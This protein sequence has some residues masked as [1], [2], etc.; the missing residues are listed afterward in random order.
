M[1]SIATWVG[2][3]TGL[4]TAW[5]EGSEV[6]GTRCRTAGPLTTTSVATFL[7]SKTVRAGMRPAGSLTVAWVGTSIDGRTSREAHSLPREGPGRRSPER[8]ELAAEQR[9]GSQPPELTPP[10]SGC[11]RCALLGLVTPGLVYG[12]IGQAGLELTHPE[13]ATENRPCGPFLLRL[14]RCGDQGTVGAIV[15][16]CQ[17]NLGRGLV[18]FAPT[19]A[20]L[21]TAPAQ[22][23][24]DWVGSDERRG[25]RLWLCLLL[26]AREKGLAK[27]LAL[28]CQELDDVVSVDMA[29]TKVRVT[30][31]FHEV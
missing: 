23:A 16:R 25:Q 19:C 3:V 18:G 15:G 27:Q 17:L 9:I 11:S 28:L 14:A 22:P 30:D 29:P 10:W 24:A 7:T 13:Q 20:R 2:W 6:A 31:L 12:R 8:W 4:V 1:P 5:V 21:V 26:P